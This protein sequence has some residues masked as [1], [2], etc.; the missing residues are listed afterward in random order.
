M[1][2]KLRVDPAT[3][4]EMPLVDRRQAHEWGI[5]DKDLM[6]LVRRGLLLRVDH[7]WYSTLVSA[8]AE[9]RHILRTVAALRSLGPEIAASA[10]SAALL[11]G[12]PLA[13]ADLTTVDLI[14]RTGHGRRREGLRIS[15]RPD[16]SAAPVAVP[17]LGDTVPVVTVS[18]A[19]VGTALRN[20]PVAALVAGDH[21]L[22]HR[23]CTPT[24]IHDRLDAHRGSKGIEGARMALR[25]LEGRHES[26]GETLT[27][28]ELRRL[29]WEVEPQ[30]EV[31]T[32]GRLYRLDFRLKGKRV[33]IEFDGEIK[34]LGQDG[35]PCPQ[36]RAEVMAA[37]EARESDLRHVGWTF[38]RFGWDDLSDPAEMH[39]RVSRAVRESEMLV[40]P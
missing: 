32:N 37:Q 3:L 5:S 10:H 19:V 8:T 15:Q 27:A 38:A 24:Q 34:Y 33:G 18:D 17:F 20:N 1:D 21:A 36:R 23:L 30:F 22:H 16:V 40:V 13:R 2:L 31:I 9:E 25:L 14:R 12:L 35:N 7:G 11:H 29:G 26:P 4:G 6:I 39:A 28:Y